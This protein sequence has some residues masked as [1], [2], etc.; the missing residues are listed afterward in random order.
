MK[1]ILLAISLLLFSFTAMASPPDQGSS[2]Q[3]ESFNLVDSV[4]INGACASCEMEVAISHE[5]VDVESIEIGGGQYGK[6]VNKTI[7][8]ASSNAAFH[9]EDPG[10]RSQ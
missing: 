6:V 1:S 8:T 9:I 5:R 7:V 3:M 4:D 2:Y 10:L